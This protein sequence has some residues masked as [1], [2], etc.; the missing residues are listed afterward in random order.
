MQSHSKVKLKFRKI[1]R[2]PSQQP[3]ST[4]LYKEYL[5]VG[6]QKYIFPKNESCYFS[7]IH[8]VWRQFNFTPPAHSA[9]P[10][11]SGWLLAFVQ[12]SWLHIQQFSKIYIKYQYFVAIIVQICRETNFSKRELHFSQV[13]LGGNIIVSTSSRQL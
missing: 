2:S 5:C 1:T 11:D 6:I 7:S 4:I 10:C 9:H 8:F 12:I 3:F 13:S